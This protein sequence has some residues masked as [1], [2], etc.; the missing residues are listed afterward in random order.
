MRNEIISS[1]ES[2][3]FLGMTLD[4]RLNWEKHINKLRAKAEKVLNTTK[5]VAGKKWEGDQK[6][7]QCNI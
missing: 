2:T 6:T 5:V 4:C 7:E 1:K 3:H